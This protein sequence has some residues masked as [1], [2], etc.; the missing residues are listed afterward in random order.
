MQ[1]IACCLL[2]RQSSGK[3][4][5]FDDGLPLTASVGASAGLAGEASLSE[6]VSVE[7]EVGAAIP[8]LLT[9]LEVSRA[10]AVAAGGVVTTFPPA[11]GGYVGIVKPGGGAWA[12]DPLPGTNELAEGLKEKL[13]ALG[14]RLFPLFWPLCNKLAGLTGGGAALS[15][16]ESS[17][18]R[19]SLC[20]G[21]KISPRVFG[22]LHLPD[23]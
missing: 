22:G 7:L 18:S 21:V 1:P 4:L 19:L 6:V 11:G 8:L 9:E 2:Q 14:L 15:S 20:R 3:H 23:S 13:A 10:G 17:I 16:H 5:P 12:C